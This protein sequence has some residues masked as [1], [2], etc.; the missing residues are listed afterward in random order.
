LI[1]YVIPVVILLILIVTLSSLGKSELLTGLV[2]VGGVAIYYFMVYLF[3][4]RLAG[5]Y[6]FYIRNTK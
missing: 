3:R 6:E 5:K 2:S 1:S 4:D